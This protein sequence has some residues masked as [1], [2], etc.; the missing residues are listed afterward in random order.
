MCMSWFIL[1]IIKF[2]CLRF[3]IVSRKTA[4][5][6][7]RQNS[8]RGRMILTAP[9]I[10]LR[11]GS[12][13]MYEDPPGYWRYRQYPRVWKWRYALGASQ[14]LAAPPILIGYESTYTFE[15]PRDI[16]GTNDTLRFENRDTYEGPPG[17]G[18]TA[19]TLGYEIWN[20]YKGLP[21][22]WRHCQYFR[23]RNKKYVWVSLRYWR[24]R[25]YSR[26]CK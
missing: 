16:G 22:Y 24:H 12:R 9:P 18:D 1:I 8:M 20:T 13:D 3:M 5:Y 19:N 15:R 25:K 23:V 4:I 7:Q 11:Y 26:V 10:F 17:N 21:W 2:L 14:V 6:K